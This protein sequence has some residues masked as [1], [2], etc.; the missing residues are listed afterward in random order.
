MKTL[1]VVDIQPEYNDWIK[2][3]PDFVKYVNRTKNNVVF[4]YN[5]AETMDMVNE[6]DY[7]W[8]LTAYGVKERVIDS[9]TFY[10]KGYAFFRNCMDRGLDHDEIVGLVKLMYDKGVNDSRDLDEDFWEEYVA[11]FGSQDFREAVEKSEDCIYIPELMDFL[12]RYDDIIICGGGE[13]QCLKEVEIALEALGKKYKRLQEY[14]YSDGGN[15]I[16][17]YEYKIG[18]L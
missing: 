2:F 11:Q 14:I 16:N 3:L 8:W 6:S 9:A 10:D 7:Q 4:L 15:I 18:G 13:H 12:N 1:L 5:G 17:E